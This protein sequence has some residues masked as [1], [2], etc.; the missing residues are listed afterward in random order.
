MDENFDE[1]ST[2]FITVMLEFAALKLAH[3]NFTNILT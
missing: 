2:L 1:K 3:Q